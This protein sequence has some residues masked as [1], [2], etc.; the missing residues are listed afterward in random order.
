MFVLIRSYNVVG[1]YEECRTD[2]NLQFGFKESF[3]HLESQSLDQHNWTRWVILSAILYRRQR[4]KKVSM[5]LYPWQPRTT[6]QQITLT[7]WAWISCIVNDTITSNGRYKRGSN[8]FGFSSVKL[9]SE[10][11]LAVS[12]LDDKFCIFVCS[13]DTLFTWLFVFDVPMSVNA[14]S[15]PKMFSFKL[16]K[17]RNTVP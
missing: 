4:G 16:M 9:I 6:K 15:S 2:Q 12:S 1:R 17:F 8:V 7:K 3:L 14:W 10:I 5:K 13:W 11:D